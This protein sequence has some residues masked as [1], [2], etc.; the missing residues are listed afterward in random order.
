M[1]KRG[2]ERRK[3][4]RTLPELDR[5]RQRRGYMTGS[6]E[7]LEAEA[8]RH[9]ERGAGI[10]PFFQERAGRGDDS[11]LDISYEKERVAEPALQEHNAQ[12]GRRSPRA[13][14]DR[15]SLEQP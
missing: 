4:R 15:R 7:V 8:A 10:A 2:R 12:E 14:P 5:R 6:V 11:T 1:P 13:L 3:G 9:F